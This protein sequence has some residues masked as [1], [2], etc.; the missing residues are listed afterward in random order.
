MR[1]TAMPR[2]LAGLALILVAL[3]GCKTT[4]TGYGDV[5]NGRD[6]RVAFTWNSDDGVS[7]EMTATMSDGRSFSGK[8]FQITSETRVDRLNPLWHGWG[9]RWPE[10]PYW[11][12]DPGPEF[13]K[14]YS[15]RVLANLTSADGE[16]MRCRFRLIHPAS[17]MA[18]GG[19][20][21]CQLPRGTHID[22]TF[23]STR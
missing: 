5:R 20:G 12:T 3:A 21:V 9:P 14:H 11:Y 23:P 18:G 4:G 2:R 19:E 17:G 1:T 16:R 10:W 6:S 15:G 22:A 7:G 8:Y 13:I